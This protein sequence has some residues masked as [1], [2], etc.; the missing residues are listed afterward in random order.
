MG[1]I[2]K[3]SLGVTWNKHE[4]ALKLLPWF[5]LISTVGV[6]PRHEPHRDNR[7]G[8]ISKNNKICAKRDATNDWLL[9]NGLNDVKRLYRIIRLM[10]TATDV[11]TTPTPFG[12]LICA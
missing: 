8:K 4:T 10:L 5:N 11:I 9:G 12:R 3:Q 1:R 7:I 2:C 6:P